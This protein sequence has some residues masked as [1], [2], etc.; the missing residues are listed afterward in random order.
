MGDAAGIGPEIIVRALADPRIRQWCVPVVLGDAR[1]LRRAM[2]VTATHVAL[3]TI[4]G[5]EELADEEDAVACLDYADVDLRTLRWGTI[6]AANGAAA[7]R[8]TQAAADMAL[9]GDVEAIVSAPLNKAAVHRAGLRYAGHTEILA[10]AAGAPAVSMVL[11]LGPMRIMLFTNHLP[12]RHA[13][14]LVVPQRILAA[15]RLAHDGLK[16]MGIPQ[17]RIAV[18]GLNPHAGEDGL[19]GDEERDGIV[20][21]VEAARAAGLDVVGPFPGDTVFLKSKAGAFDL[22]L[23]LYHDQ[24]LMAA[25]LLG[26]GSLVTLLFGL[27]FIRTSVGHGTAYDIAGTGRAEHGNMIE[28]IR[29]AAELGRRPWGPRA[30][31]ADRSVGGG[32]LSGT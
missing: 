17:P 21:A 22:T 25:K 29:V 30:A 31:T 7:V 2:E 14:D 20:P 3:R 8:Y 24:G 15:L 10:E 13:C 26:F 27:P 23:A 12:L 28:A 11:L 1:V 5:L 6:A 9:R 18:A 19:F 16:A 4:T 32:P